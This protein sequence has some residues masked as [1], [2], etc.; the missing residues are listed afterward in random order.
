MTSNSVAIRA[1]DDNLRDR[2]AAGEAGAEFDATAGLAGQQIIWCR[3]PDTD[4]PL[5]VHKNRIYWIAVCGIEG[6]AAFG[7][8]PTG[9]NGHRLAVH[10]KVNIF[11]GGKSD[12]VRD[13]I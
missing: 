7:N 13:P 4:L 6:V 5:A 8:L 2:P 9:R 10:R 11:S 12:L 1:T 3:R